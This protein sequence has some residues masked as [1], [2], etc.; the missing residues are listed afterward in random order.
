MAKTKFNLEN[1]KGLVKLVN[2]LSSKTTALEVTAPAVPQP[3]IYKAYITQSGTNA[4]VEDDID[5][6]G[7]G[8]PFVDTLGGTWSHEGTGY[9]YYTKVGAFADASKIRVVFD[10]SAGE[11]GADIHCTSYR[12]DNDTIDVSSFRL[13]QFA[14]PGVNSKENG[15]LYK[16]GITIEVY[17]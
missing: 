8:R 7:S 17:P 16:Q 10:D 9:F 1:Y 12:V 5:G 6:G 3:M 13:S 14:S 15:I 11:Q 2:S 4:P